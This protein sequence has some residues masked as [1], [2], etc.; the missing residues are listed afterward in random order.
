MYS[1][2]LQ[3]ATKLLTSFSHFRLKAACQGGWWLSLTRKGQG[4]RNRVCEEGLRYFD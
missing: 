1:K 3:P 4:G 2:T